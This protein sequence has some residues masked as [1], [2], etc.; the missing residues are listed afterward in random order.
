MKVAGRTTAITPFYAMEVLK[1]AN[2]RAAQGD[3][4]LHMEVGEP[5]GGAPEAVLQ[6]A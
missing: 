1:A 3:D 4:V 5:A 2:E 6:A